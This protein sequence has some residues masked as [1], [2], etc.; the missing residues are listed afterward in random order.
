MISLKKYLDMDSSELK[1]H[2]EASPDELLLLLLG[3]YRSALGAMG[4]C[5]VAT[6]PALGGELERGL[7]VAAERLARK[8]TPP[9]L[10]ETE[11]R[12]RHEL[13]QWG[14]RAGEYFLERAGDV[15]EIL[16]VLAHA[17]EST[18]ERHERYTRQFGEF[19]QRLQ[20]MAKLEDL[21]QIRAA[22]MRGARDL[23][24]CVDKMEEDGRESVA[25]LRAQVDTYQTKLEQAEQLACRDAL[26]GLDNRHGIETKIE[27]RIAEQRPFCVVMLDL[28]GFKRIN[29]S[30]GH[31]VGD[32]LL[33]QFSA[34]LRSASRSTD[35]VGRWGGDEFIVVMEGGVTEAQSHLERMQK[36]VFGGYAVQLEAAGPKVH[37]DAALGMVEWHSGE[38]LKEVLG[39]ADAVMY[40]QKAL[41][42]QHPR[43]RSSALP[44]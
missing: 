1:K 2:R 18:A 9:V 13:E 43:T 12:I 44:N 29:D 5:G 36:W 41:A 23:E 22:V 6:C 24:V 8:L 25:A 27:R 31:L 20:A 21:P 35:A 28:N 4:A 38:S 11:A 19:T 3:S 14:G 40:Q 7:M 34:E 32:D 16:M 17:A 39:R 15:K 37:M 42:H 30:Y 33:K 26:T 10:Q